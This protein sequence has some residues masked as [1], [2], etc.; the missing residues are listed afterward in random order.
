MYHRLYSP[1]TIQQHRTR[2]AGQYAAQQTTK[3]TPDENLNSFGYFSSRRNPRPFLR[4]MTSNQTLTIR[5][6]IAM[7]KIVLLTS[8]VRREKKREMFRL[9]GAAKSNPNIISLTSNIRCAPRLSQRWM[10]TSSGGSGSGSGGPRPL[11][12]VVLSP[13]G[14]PVRARGMSTPA[15]PDRYYIVMTD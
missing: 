10:A 14:N 4:L 11:A 13:S 5:M 2:F 15:I 12:N 1:G 7:Q 6:L 3:P 8:L 9:I